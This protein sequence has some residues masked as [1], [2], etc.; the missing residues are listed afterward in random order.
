VRRLIPL[1][2][3]D[4]SRAVLLKG[5]MTRLAS[6][7]SVR[8]AEIVVGEPALVDSSAP[9]DLLRVAECAA[10]ESASGRRALAEACQAVEAASR[11]WAA[12]KAAR[13][14]EVRLAA[15]QEVSVEL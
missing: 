7:V 4:L 14:M 11:R 15:G 9:V 10:A 8:L 12:A 13:L 1:V 6:S 3:A 5:Q 2:L